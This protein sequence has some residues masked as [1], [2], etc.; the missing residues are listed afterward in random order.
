MAL[1]KTV[2][3]AERVE[4]TPRNVTTYRSPSRVTIATKP[5][6]PPPVEYM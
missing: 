5:L 1:A 3:H 2:L 4:S 6:V